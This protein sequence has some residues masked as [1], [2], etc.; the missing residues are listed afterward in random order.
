MATMNGDPNPDRQIE[1]IMELGASG[2]I[3][4]GKI[5]KGKIEKGKIEKGNGLLVLNGRRCG[6]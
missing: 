3:E 2:K 4:K 5:E 6:G 1:T